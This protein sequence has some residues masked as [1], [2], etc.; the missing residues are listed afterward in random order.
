MAGLEEGFCALA[1]SGW[2]VAV[3]RAAHP[4]LDGS[5]VAVLSGGRVLEV[6][7]EAARAGVSAGMTPRQA[8]STLPSV[9]TVE[10]D[11]ELSMR[12]FVPIVRALFDVTPFVQ[13]DRPGR[14]FFP[15]KGV[16]GF[17]DSSR[18]LAERVLDSLPSSGVLAPRADTVPS[19]GIGMAPSR[20]ASFL[21]ALGAARAS[22]WMVLDEPEPARRFLAALPVE[23]LGYAVEPDDPHEIDV[24]HLLGIRTLG[25]LAG[26]DPESLSD[27]FGTWAVKA[28]ELA[29]GRDPEPPLPAD[30][31]RGLAASRHF[32]PPLRDFER[33][34]FAC[35]ELGVEL[36]AALAREAL[37]CKYLRLDVVEQA[38][39]TTS[40][41]WRVDTSV[42]AAARSCR[43]HLESLSVSSPVTDLRLSPLDTVPMHGTQL[44]MEGLLGGGLSGEAQWDEARR[45]VVR[46]EAILGEEAAYLVDPELSG[47]A[48][49][50]L[51]HEEAG[52]VALSLFERPPSL[53]SS[54]SIPPRSRA[55]GSSPGACGTRGMSPPG[56][57]P[58]PYPVSVFEVEITRDAS[59]VQ[60][61]SETASGRRRASS[62]P[63][64]LLVGKPS[65]A[66]TLERRSRPVV[67]RRGPRRTDPPESVDGLPVVQAA[68]PWSYL[69]R[70]WDER[71]SFR[72][73]MWQV[74]LE[75]AGSLS[76]RLIFRGEDGLWYVYG[77]YD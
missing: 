56:A 75:E 26:L 64:R 13:I 7:P 31:P 29:N 6:S 3:A 77:A 34:L 24:W 23:V 8:H 69:L 51:P 36:G 63:P 41:A 11:E 50:R 9:A 5:P 62:T 65:R 33:L 61:T 47:P 10:I 52:L 38:G 1:V 72:G 57:L 27:R 21:A 67:V 37:T 40:L 74:V 32:D 19:V 44:A 17:Y 43:W 20:F 46:A 22:G 12:A 30:P 15:L 54:R 71:R 55:P 68:G 42:E 18:A 25:D 28:W 16:L 14:L 4:E 45:V 59:R 70:W 58:L 48:G 2:D 76:G 35:G 39:R 60:A 53:P 49:G 73:E 66:V